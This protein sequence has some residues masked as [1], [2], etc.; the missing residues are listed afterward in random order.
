MTTRERYQMELNGEQYMVERWPAERF[1]GWHIEVS[2]G[3]LRPAIA[4]VVDNPSLVEDY[5]F[6]MINTIAVGDSDLWAE[7]VTDLLHER[8]LGLK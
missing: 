5:G 3:D 2:G 8:E 7:V 4:T 6:Q 1:R